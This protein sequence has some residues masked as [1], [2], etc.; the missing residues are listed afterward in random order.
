MR[1][2]F[3]QVGIP[4]EILDGLDKAG[5]VIVPK[6]PTVTMIE[7]AYWSALAESAEG[8]WRE[9]VGQWEKCATPLA[10]EILREAIACSRAS[11]TQ[12]S[13]S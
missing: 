3:R 10:V 12:K 6:E 5:F 7:E 2:E 4:T 11:D 8:V 9:M 13:D 1:P